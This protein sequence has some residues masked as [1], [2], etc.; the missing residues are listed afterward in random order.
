MTGEGL[1]SASLRTMPCRAF[2]RARK[3]AGEE[4]IRSPKNVSIRAAV[5][6]V[7]IRWP[8]RIFSINEVESPVPAARSPNC[9][10]RSTINSFSRFVG[11]CVVNLTHIWIHSLQQTDQL[12]SFKSFW[13][14]TTMFGLMA[15][16]WWYNQRLVGE[17][18]K[19]ARARIGMSIR[20]LAGRSGVSTSQV[21]RVESGEFDIMLSTL[22]KLARHLGVPAGFVLEQGAIP[23]VGFYAK[24]IGEAGVTPLLNEL[25][26]GKRNALPPNSR[27][28]TTLFCA[29]IALAAACLIQSSNA[30]QLAKLIDSPVP[31]L[32]IALARFAEML[33]G[34]IM[35]DRVALQRELDSTPLELLMRFKLVTGDIAA[36][37]A[38]DSREHANLFP[39]LFKI[40]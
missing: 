5:R 31:A 1:V 6:A 14:L 18:L 11:V 13:S 19:R 30:P 38:I 40:V 33:S 15:E 37:F 25:P 20:D 10:S 12:F 3:A 34:V 7:G 9:R 27:T 16:P 39:D 17:I 35:E 28:R 24:L 32:A 21:L 23:N 26:R 8:A 29:Q 22:L 4:K 2:R 36:A